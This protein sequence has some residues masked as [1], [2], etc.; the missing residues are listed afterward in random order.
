M[1]KLLIVFITLLF[2]FNCKQKEIEKS[3][4]IITYLEGEVKTVINNKEELAKVGDI[5][6]EEDSII[7]NKDSIAEIKIGENSIIKINPDTI[8]KIEILLKNRSIENSKVK[9]IKG[10]IFTKCNKLNTGSSFE[11]ETKSITVGV[12]GTEFLVGNEEGKSNVTVIKGDVA[13]RKNIEIKKTTE[14]EKVDP[15]LATHIKENL[16]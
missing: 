6:K 5:L 11:V 15:I 14:L 13:V 10:E 16:L 2:I 8:L 12:R 9:I 3:Q 1:R 7:T 4:C